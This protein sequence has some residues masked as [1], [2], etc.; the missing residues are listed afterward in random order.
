MELQNSTE[1]GD[2]AGRAEVA[3]VPQRCL[4]RL[5]NVFDRVI[6]LPLSANADVMIYN[7][8]NFYCFVVS[9]TGLTDGQVQLHLI[10]YSPGMIKLIVGE[11]GMVRDNMELD[12]WRYRLS[13]LARP[14]LA[15]V[16]CKGGLLV[17]IVP[18]A[19]TDEN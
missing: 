6:E 7:F 12:R 2:N 15:L 11:P 19:A 16:F 5:P 18:K 4:C 3:T 14:E 9:S 10:R 1:V 13:E 17:V 8:A